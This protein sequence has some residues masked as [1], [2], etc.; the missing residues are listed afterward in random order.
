MK[1]EEGAEEWRVETTEL[2]R[3]YAPTNRMLK[4]LTGL[5]RKYI[6]LLNVNESVLICMLPGIGNQCCIIL[7]NINSGSFM[8]INFLCVNLYGPWDSQIF[9]QT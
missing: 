6:N 4:G 3:V 7:K 9:S 1:H 5:F 8:M 2:H